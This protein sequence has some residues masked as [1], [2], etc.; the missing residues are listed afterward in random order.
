MVEQVELAEHLGNAQ[1]KLIDS[2]EG[3]DG[4]LLEQARIG[5]MIT[6]F[7]KENLEGVNVAKLEAEV[8]KLRAEINLFYS[9]VLALKEVK[10]PSKL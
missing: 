8:A 9:S 3:H 7:L 1:I 4:F 5:P 6:Q 2:E 10:V